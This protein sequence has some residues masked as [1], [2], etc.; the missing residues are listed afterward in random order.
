[1]SYDIEDS[2]THVADPRRGICIVKP[3]VGRESGLPV[4]RLAHPLNG[5]H[6]T[7]ADEALDRSRHQFAAGQVSATRLASDPSIAARAAL[8][9]NE[10]IQ[11]SPVT[12]GQQCADRFLRMSPC[13][14]PQPPA[15]RALAER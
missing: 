4:R 3:S 7:A 12:A 5:W 15:A 13:G 11:T 1:M 6:R 10:T 9:R 2:A 14:S 8:A